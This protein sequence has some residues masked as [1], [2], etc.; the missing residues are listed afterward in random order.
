MAKLTLC[1][2]EDIAEILLRRTNEIASFADDYR[3]NDSHFGSVEM[4]LT[5]EIFRLRR[6]AD[7]VNQMAATDA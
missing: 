3:R 6:L 7:V 5:R 2:R 4:A 1:D